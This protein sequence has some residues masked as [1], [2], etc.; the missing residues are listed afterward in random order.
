MALAWPSTVVPMAKR[1]R[2]AAVL[3]RGSS[4]PC[5]TPRIYSG[6]CSLSQDPPMH[7]SNR[8]VLQSA[9]LAMQ[10]AIYSL[11]AI[12]QILIYIFDFLSLTEKVCHLP[13][14]FLKSVLKGLICHHVIPSAKVGDEAL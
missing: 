8:V 9:N 14:C 1:G 11:K 10:A 6:P 13:F 7:C 3:L 4:S 5:E 12:H 2:G